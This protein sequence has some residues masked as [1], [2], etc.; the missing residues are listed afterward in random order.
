[1]PHAREKAGWYA[2]GIAVAAIR[3]VVIEGKALPP[4]IRVAGI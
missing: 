1:V 2:A 4:V 3:V